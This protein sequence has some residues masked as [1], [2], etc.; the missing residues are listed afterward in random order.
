MASMSATCD[1]YAI[2]EIESDATV[3]TIRQAYKRLA[4]ARHPDKQPDN[5]DATAEFQT[6]QAA[7]ETLSDQQTREA[8]D[9]DRAEKTRLAEE[10]R[11]AGEK[12]QKRSRRRGEKKAEKKRE[13]EAMRKAEEERR[14]EEQR[15]ADAKRETEQE[16]QAEETRLHEEEQDRKAEIVHW[17]ALVAK[18]HHLS[19][20][21]LEVPKLVKE[22]EV[23]ESELRVLKG[24]H[25]NGVPPK[26][27]KPA[28]DSTV[29]THL[30]MK[31]RLEVYKAKQMI[32]DDPS[33]QNRRKHKAALLRLKTFEILETKNLVKFITAQIGELE[34]E[35]DEIEDRTTEQKRQAW[36]EHKQAWHPVWAEGAGEFS[37]MSK[38][39]Q[40][41]QTRVALECPE[42]RL[43]WCRQCHWRWSSGFGARGGD[44][45]MKSWADLQHWLGQRIAVYRPLS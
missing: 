21:Q 38:Y 12:K 37:C 22:L 34:G 27:K 36:C 14:R 9:Q 43:M 39:C 8:Y 33:C 3:Q 6:L 29:D 31:T 25:H 16:R 4:L 1:Y 42:C 26:T 24:H 13:A 7:V 41:S 35:L 45:S 15:R 20:W 11:R 30:V 2:L 44:E 40:R 19:W 5:P 18:R 10:E 23:F 28:E 17:R 32:Q